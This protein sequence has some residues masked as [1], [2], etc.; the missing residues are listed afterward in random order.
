VSEGLQKHPSGILVET[1]GE[2]PRSR[3]LSLAKLHVGEAISDVN[4]T[5]YSDELRGGYVFSI[6]DDRSD[7]KPL[8]IGARASSLIYL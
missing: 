4:R 6:Y 1:R 2:K 5:G 8:S 7:P 3:D